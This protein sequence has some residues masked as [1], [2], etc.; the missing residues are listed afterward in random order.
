MGTC[1]LFA[2]LVVAIMLTGCAAGVSRPKAEAEVEDKF[3]CT[4]QSPVGEV[5]VSLTEAGREDFKDNTQFDPDKL[6]DYLE[7]ALESRS[8][9][10]EESDT[11]L[12]YVVV[13]IKDIRVRSGFNAMIFGFM[14][15]NDH[16]VG[17]VVVKDAEG[18]EIDRFEVSSSYAFGGLAGGQ[19][20]VRLDWLYKSF[21]DEAVAELTAAQTR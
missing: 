18:T 8:L 3:C 4:T 14:A 21:A 15:G 2:G 7:R 6:E 17:D 1:R 11:E 12:P 13:E 5:E 9:L 16:L 10:K 20:S 19:D